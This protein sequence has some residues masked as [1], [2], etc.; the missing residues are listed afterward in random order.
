MCELQLQAAQ[1]V[2]AAQQLVSLGQA[3]AA[4]HGGQP[5]PVSGLQLLNYANQNNSN[6]NSSNNGSSEHNLAVAL[7][8]IILYNYILLIAEMMFKYVTLYL[9]TLFYVIA[10]ANVKVTLIRCLSVQVYR[11]TQASAAWRP[12]RTRARPQQK[13]RGPV[14][15]ARFRSHPRLSYRLILPR[16]RKNQA[17]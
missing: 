16:T 13:N 6:N 14:R 9:R 12:R 3:A 11:A 7:G 2:A 17:R 4:A 8:E 5:P 1:Q 15:R 10:A